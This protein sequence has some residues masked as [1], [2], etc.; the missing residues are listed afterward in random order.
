MNLTCCFVVAEKSRFLNIIL[1]IQL[2]QE[3]KTCPPMLS[4]LHMLY[5]NNYMTEVSFAALRYAKF[6]NLSNDGMLMRFKPGFLKRIFYFGMYI[7][8]RRTC[9]IQ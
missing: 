5:S 6:R 4:V 2:T 7:R 1:H 9:T 3:K 8:D